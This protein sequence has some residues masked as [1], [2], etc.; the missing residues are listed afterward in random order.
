MRPSGS[1]TNLVLCT[2]DDNAVDN[3][4][5]VEDDGSLHRPEP[6]PVIPSGLPGSCECDGLAAR[7][8]TMEAMPNPN[9]T[10]SSLIPAEPGDLCAVRRGARIGLLPLSRQAI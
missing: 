6:I 5:Q 10:P 7:A 1:V 3:E 2:H 9:G 8:A 4:Q